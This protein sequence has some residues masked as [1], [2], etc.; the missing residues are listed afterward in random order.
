[1]EIG[2]VRVSPAGL[3][4]LIALVERGEINPNSGK[5]VLG[6]MFDSGRAAKD[7]VQALGLSQ[8]SDVE[9][10]ASIV[11]KVIEAN[12][13]QVIKYRSGKESVFNWLLGQV[14]RETRGKGNP[15][16]VRELLERALREP[17]AK[18]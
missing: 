17:A 2:D 16:L 10:L 9:A 1:M 8:V 18:E 12:E 11:A 3:A 6:D 15:A 13:D 14:M 4:E 5:R 7:V